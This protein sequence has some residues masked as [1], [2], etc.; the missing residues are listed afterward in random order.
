MTGTAR[1]FESRSSVPDLR[2]APPAVAAWLVAWQGRLLPPY[3]LVGL[4]ACLALG[5]AGVLVRSRSPRAAVVAAALVGAAAAGL[6]TSARVQSRTSGPLADGA[7]RS[8]AV[9][10]EARLLEDPRVVPAKG[11]VLA[12]RDLVVVR[13]RAERLELAGRAVSLRQ[14]V[15]VVSDDR[16]WLGMLPSQRVRVEG[17]LR[18]AERGDDVAALLS[19]RG[20][21]VV[22]AAPSA[23]QRA[24]GRL[25]Q[26][27][28]DA[29]APLPADERG[30]LPGLVAGDTSRLS[31]QLR[32]DFRATGLSHLV[33]VSG[34]NVAIVLAAALAL[35]GV[36]GVRLRWRAPLAALVLLGFVVLARPSP[37]VLRATAMGLIA[38]LALATGT[39]RQA[40]PALCG[41][42]LALLLLSPELAAQPGFALSTLATA[43][44]LLIA[45]TWRDRLARRLPRWAAEALAVP[46]AAQYACTPVVVAIS[47]SLGLLS[48]PA[49]LLA[50]PAVAPATVLGV[51]AALLAP[52]WLP[53]AQ[54][55]AW[56]AYLPARWLAVI[57]HTGARQP[58]AGAAVPR[59]WT[60]ALIALSLMA[61]GA[62]VLRSPQLRRAAAAVMAGVVVAWAAVIV[63]RPPWP[64]P[65]W[66]MVGCDV[67]QGD[68]FVVRLGPG[69]ALVVDTGPRTEPIDGCLR[70]LGVRRVPLLVLT[71]LHADHVEGVPGL[72]R[73]RQVGLVELGPLDEPR[74]ELERVT[75][76]LAARSIP[77]TR[78]V[79]G[80]VREQ[81]G[82]RWEV[83]DATARRGTSSDPNNSSIVMRL[84]TGGI[85]VLFPGDVEAQA[86]SSLRARG[87]DLRAD[88]LKVPHHGSRNQDPA[89]LDAVQATVALTPVG[90][91]NPYAHPYP[92]TLERLRAGGARTYRSDLDGDVA[93]LVRDGRVR[94]VGRSGDGSPPKGSPL[95][96]QPAEQHRVADQE[97]TAAP[98]VVP[99]AGRPCSGR[100]SCAAPA[101]TGPRARAPPE[102]G[103]SRRMARWAGAGSRRPGPPD[104]RRRG[105]GAAGLPG[106]ERGRPCGQDAQRRDRGGRPGGLGPRRGRPGRGPQPLAVRRRAGGRHPRRAGAGQGGRRGRARLRRRPG[107]GDLRGRAARGRP[108]GQGPHH[109]AHRC[110]GAA[111]R[112]RQGH[113]GQ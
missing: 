39:A 105:G 1:L 18:P 38:L 15:L 109:L 59:G 23:V 56:L 70:R 66:V 20:P 32:D 106:G 77:T 11:D 99:A 100:A 43:G 112:L 13:V 95:N 89:F 73:G 34:T 35:C 3:L 16:R 92:G 72:L 96:G 47:G 81:G 75:R 50:V 31:P 46:A 21:P 19:A 111:G 61:A 76:W 93:V 36:L 107:A 103:R 51:L 63:F 67:G 74:V 90:A 29:V 4:S 83:L 62:V 80:E 64:P 78:A 30:L 53:A 12:F 7:K 113:Q 14:P 98:T 86:Q 37:S 49:N 5:A 65:G 102:A 27:M 24:A 41:A 10:I 28:R 101:P 60:G 55:V 110:G 9:A 40:L 33:A 45:P 94:A 79:A 91:G 85:T 52:V 84:Q 104:A 97:R 82:V 71:H 6:A 26:G 17:R 2:L 44:L 22:L 87:L 57:A 42:V 25:R 69:T 108:E 88:V 58:G 48:V 68:G 54:A 8:A